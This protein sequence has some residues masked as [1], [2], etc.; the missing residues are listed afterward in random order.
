MF[1]ST[2]ELYDQLLL[3][4]KENSLELSSRLGKGIQGLV[5]STLQKTAL[6]VHCRKEAYE[7]EKNA[8]LR[9]REKDIQKIRNL[10]IPKFVSSNDKLLIIE[11]SIVSPPYLLDFGSA[12][13]DYPPEHL[14]EENYLSSPDSDEES[15]ERKYIIQMILSDLEYQAGIFFSDTHKWNIA[16][17]E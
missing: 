1:L 13:L 2:K 7:R 11:M 15:Q 12:Y 8:Y 9:L 5:F 14:L 6:K 4:C 10:A 16:L 17:E 3:Y